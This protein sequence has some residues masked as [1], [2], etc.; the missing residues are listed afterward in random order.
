M[1]NALW[2]CETICMIKKIREKNIIGGDMAYFQ[3]CHY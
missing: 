2:L 1:G 3:V